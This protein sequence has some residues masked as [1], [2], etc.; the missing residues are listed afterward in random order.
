MTATGTNSSS[1]KAGIGSPVLIPRSHPGR[2][3]RIWRKVTTRRTAG[4]RPEI[5]L[6]SN[7][8]DLSLDWVVREIRHRGVDYLRLN[9]ERSAEISWVVDPRSGSWH[10]HGLGEPTALDR[11]RSVLYRRPEPPRLSGLNGSDRRLARGQWAAL[12]AGLSSLDA[13]WISPP[14]LI[15]RAESKILQIRTAVS[16]GLTVPPTLVTNSRASARRFAQREGPSVVVK[17][18]DAPLVGPKTEEG[19][20]FSTLVLA[21][22]L[23]DLGEPDLAPVIVQRPIAPK[24][25]LRVTVVGTRVLAAKAR[26]D[27]FDWRRQE[28]PPI[29]EVVELQS[30]LEAKAVA[31]VQRLGLA[32][33]ALDFV[34]DARG[35]HFFL[36]LNAN[37]EWGWLQR[38]GLPIA[39][40]I[41][42]ELLNG[43]NKGPD[44]C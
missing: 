19:F 25:D 3:R 43:T 41:V 5:L 22:Q 40:A 30:D 12:I 24:V 36:E 27:T 8:R 34:V 44:R 29:F 18:L 9:T 14:H 42:D 37:G 23:A 20:V 4:H 28:P 26:A 6:L 1:S 13:R 7:E 31:L 35:R 21:D 38:A 39:E 32:F 16:V 10:L 15:S 2:R 33:G 17:G 11:V